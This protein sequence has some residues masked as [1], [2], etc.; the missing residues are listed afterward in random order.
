MTRQ[1][2]T[3]CTLIVVGLMV[4]PLGAAETVGGDPVHALIVNDDGV[5]A[6]GI[7]A[8]AAVLAAD[9]AYRVTVAAPAEQ[10]SVTG[11]G[12]VTRR[13]VEEAPRGRCRRRLPR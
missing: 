9:P 2:G 3:L 11:H 4:L 1:L 5:D 8:L 12:L 7:A 6:P 13:E 10:Q